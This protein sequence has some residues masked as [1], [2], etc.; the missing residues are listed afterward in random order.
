MQP[1]KTLQLPVI[2]IEKGIGTQRSAYVVVYRDE[3]VKVPMFN[4]Q[5]NQPQ[6]SVI[7]CDMD[8][9]NRITQSNMAITNHYYPDTTKPYLFKVRTKRSHLKYYEIDDT[10]ID[11][12][13]YK[14]FLPFSESNPGLMDGQSILCRIKQIND[15]RPYLTL[16][17][18]NPSLISFQD[19]HEVFGV[20]DGCRFD[21]WLRALLDE[22]FMQ[23]TAE[24]YHK[25]DGRWVCS[26][27]G[28]VSRLIFR[29]LDSDEDDKRGMLSTL[30]HGWIETIERSTFMRN[31]SAVER[32]QYTRDLAASIEVCEDFI[33]A[34]SSRWEQPDIDNVIAS[35]DPRFY[36]YRVE[37]RFRMLACALGLDNGLLQHSIK[38]ILG[39]VE[40]MGEEKC[41][42]TE[43]CLPLSFLL[44]RYTAI[45]TVGIEHSVV[46][47]WKD[48]S[49]I[50]R[51][52][53]ALCYLSRMQQ[54]Q[55]DKNVLVSIGK[56]YRLVSAYMS[57]DNE[58]QLLLKNAYR[59]MFSSACPV[60]SFRWEVMSEIVK[61]RLYLLCKDIPQNNPREL[62][63]AGG[64]CLK[65]T[66][67]GI[68]LAPQN[69][70]GTWVEFGL[71]G[72]LVARMSYGKG[73]AHLEEGADFLQ[74][75]NAWNELAATV[76]T[77]I[78][79]VERKPVKLRDG[80]ET[81]IYITGIIDER[82][83][84][85]RAVDSGEEGIIKFNDL[86]CYEKP[87]LTL[88]DFNGD[89]GRPMLFPAVCHIHDDGI[90][91][92]AI[93][94]KIDF[95]LDEVGN[96]YDEVLC[97]VLKEI[98]N[99]LYVCATDKG[100]LVL[101]DSKREPLAPFSFVK[102]SILK[103]S[104]NDT[105]PYVLTRFEDY[106]DERFDQHTPYA[107]YLRLFNRYV[108]GT[109]TTLGNI[110]GEQPLKKSSSAS[111]CIPAT[112]GQIMS[113]AGTL[114]MMSRMERNL[115]RRYGYLMICKLL[116]RL[117]GDA[118]AEEY[119]AIRLK[120]TAL[121][122]S[123]SVNHELSNLDLQRFNEST[124]RF[125]DV[126]DI[127]LR[128]RILYM[129]SRFNRWHN[130]GNV[131]YEL[132]GLLTSDA[133]ILEKE[134]ARLILS[135][136]MLSNFGNDTLQERILDEIGRLL[137]MD[138]IHPNVIHIGEES[139]TCEFKTS[140]VFPPDSHGNED[141]EQQ[142]DNIIRVILAMMNTNGGLLYIGVNDSGNVVGLHDD[143]AYFSDN[144]TV[145]E[146]KARDNFTNHFSCLLAERLGA[147]KAARFSYGFREYGDYSVFRVEIPAMHDES[148][149]LFRVGNTVQRK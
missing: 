105:S 3:E 5:L 63:Y 27:A 50:K 55:G 95:V 17:D 133:P 90:T 49:A 41:C 40:E 146:T 25:H 114:S 136:Y 36:Q 39:R 30:C 144:H 22:P 140:I 110:E 24:L 23:A 83:A 48:T 66:S 111:S 94:Y 69:Y 51:S 67:R 145:D 10:R 120:Y 75:Q 119:Y 87:N 35:L 73:I 92:D 1:I 52:I 138:I 54:R 85:C 6:P 33:D 134:L 91:F 97:A 31:L 60:M 15:G 37:R 44:K 113:V 72:D 103:K 12:E 58:K 130:H 88:A 64:T 14:L 102:A 46:S 104:S 47:V 19:I 29:I 141:I 108:Y 122:Y 112:A 132:V 65:M 84:K 68:E 32:Q 128:R 137:G 34:L 16:E 61:S 123:F 80:D 28:H 98:K 82:T 148:V 124:E 116:M 56:I 118:E 13:N 139:Q 70:T 100:F 89:D 109:E 93:A 86:L 26:M 99:G 96:E 43:I 129:L 125:K 126:P 131:D 2:R 101:V 71:A 107:S 121:L 53:L 142:S 77:P 106:A 38:A 78:P 115:R 42:E 143:M 135:S 18:A 20:R 147:E 11:E 7:V 57:G 62:T 79:K 59:S 76:F 74:V 149:N 117:L 127:D 45:A 4:F 9:K 81:D 21:L 8:G